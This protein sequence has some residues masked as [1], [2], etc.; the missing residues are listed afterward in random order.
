MADFTCKYLG[1]PK[2]GA[3]S[4]LTLTT[5]LVCGMFGATHPL[6]KIF[7]A[8]LPVPGIGTLI[9]RIG[10]ALK[11]L[12]YLEAVKETLDTYEDETVPTV[13]FCKYYPNE[14]V[15]DVTWIDIV[16]ALSPFGNGELERKVANYT[17]IQLW[18]DNCQ[19][20]GKTDIPGYPPDPDPIPVPPEPDPGDR[21][22]LAQ[23]GYR[24]EV[25]SANVGKAFVLSVIEANPDVPISNILSI[26]LNEPDLVNGFPAN[27]W[28]P[29]ISEQP[30]DPEGC[31]CFYV[32][33]RSVV[34]QF[35]D[36]V[37]LN[38]NVV[39]QNQLG[40]ATSWKFLQW[41]APPPPPDDPENLPIFDPDFL[42]DFCDLFP[43]VEACVKCSN[44]EHQEVDV[45]FNTACDQSGIITWGIDVVQG[46]NG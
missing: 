5:G 29:L 37:Y 3:P 9:K 32:R 4:E 8:I 35:V 13:E 17:A 44:A 33:T 34:Y 45:P 43:E 14:P 1:E 42:E 11:G 38:G 18:N 7:D 40:F 46:G 39:P 41:C 15:E 22:Y 28:R 25:I 6:C 21:C 26:E 24:T 31:Y 27:Y 2:D 20:K 23:L 36:D 19:C 10:K 12:K 16:S 30:P